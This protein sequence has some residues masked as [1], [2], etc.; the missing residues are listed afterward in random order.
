MEHAQFWNSFNFGFGFNF[1]RAQ[2]AA[3]VR[4][5][6]EA[7]KTKQSTALLA[8]QLALTST[9]M[10]QFAKRIAILGSQLGRPL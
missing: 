1:G 8:S 5:A 2:R 10:T 7:H 3:Q 6:E 9:K 4:K